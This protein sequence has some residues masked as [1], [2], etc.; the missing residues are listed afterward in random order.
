MRRAALCAACLLGASAV[1]S[2]AQMEF[3][4]QPL[5][6]SGISEKNVEMRGRWVRQWTNPDGE[7]VLVY[8]GG[9]R[10][11]FGQRRLAAHNAVV[12]IAVQ[13]SPAAEHPYYELIVYLAEE[14][15]VLEPGGTFTRDD[16]LLVRGLRTRG[17][18]IKHQDAHAPENLEGSPLYQQALS[19]RLALSAATELAELPPGPEVHRP[20]PPAPQ[21]ARRQRLIR[22]RVEHIEPVRTP[23]DEPIYIGT[24]GVYFAQDG[25][26]DAPV[27]EIRAATAVIFPR[28]GAQEGLGA[29]LEGEAPAA[30]QPLV[31]KPPL[32]RPG[33][34]REPLPPGI[35][36]PGIVPP[37][38]TT[39]PA[40]P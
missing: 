8:N 36:P 22:Y 28:A 32:L 1:P 34:A 11:D 21:V 39:A 6:A 17:Q 31:P 30:Q 13:R 4:D 12:W 7:L 23:A 40:A 14:A 26:P 25:G 9:F 33:E 3:P 16:V 27:L 10:L 19:D 38:P 5:L 2:P 37:P 29:A 20:Q 18:I 35:A 24:G 15:E